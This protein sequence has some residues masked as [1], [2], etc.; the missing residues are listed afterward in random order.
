VLDDRAGL[1]V[2]VAQK[3]SQP[4]Y[5][6]PWLRFQPTVSYVQLNNSCVLETRYRLKKR[7]EYQVTK[8]LMRRCKIHRHR[9]HSL[10]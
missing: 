3:N 5:F 8:A 2:L 9:Y 1:L 10:S 6:W 4:C 7:I